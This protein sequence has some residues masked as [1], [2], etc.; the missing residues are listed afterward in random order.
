MP[1]ANYHVVQQAVEHLFG[2]NNTGGALQAFLDANCDAFVDAP[3]V[4][5]TE[6]DEQN[7]EFWRLF[8]NYTRLYEEHL[9]DYIQNVK[10]V[11]TQEFFQICK[12]ISD[13][14][15]VT[16]KKLKHFVSLLLSC[17]EYANFYKMMVRAARRVSTG[18]VRP[19]E[20]KG[21][22]APHRAEGKGGGGGGGDDDDKASSYAADAKESKQS[23]K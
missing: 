9:T 21:S 3:V 6:Q 18:G 15:L 17:T 5:P 13:D 11:S 1:G 23:F 4:C 20:D 16:D 22:G 8:Q 2:K 12:D 14:E 10:D 19:A 7:L